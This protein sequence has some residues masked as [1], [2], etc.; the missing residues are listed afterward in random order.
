MTIPGFIVLSSL[1][2]ASIAFAAR[3]QIRTL[4][5]PLFQARYFNALMLFQ[6]MI[7]APIG[8]YFYAFYPDWS[9]MYM[10]NTADSS[11]A[12]TVMAI[13]SY[14]IAG[15]MGY[16][17]GYYSAKSSSNWITIVFIAF[18]FAGLVG[19]FAVAH[20]KILTVGTYHQYHRAVGT[21]KLSSTSLLPSILLSV[22]GIGVCWSYLIRTLTLGRHIWSE[23]IKKFNNF[24][25]GISGN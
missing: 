12:I 10:V 8:V 17:V 14:P 13:I 3:V 1:I 2:G 22:T 18:M 21:Q 9:W 25:G 24:K 5:K 19:L 7:F 16:L 20:D 11:G 6:L 23:N 4:Q 15:T